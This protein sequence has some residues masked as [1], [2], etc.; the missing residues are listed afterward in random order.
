[1]VYY[2]F[3]VCVL[4]DFMMTSCIPRKFLAMILNI[5]IFLINKENKNIN[6]T[7]LNL[8]IK[9]TS[10]LRLPVFLIIIRS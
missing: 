1:M 2:F 6:M 8:N 3:I 9:Q 4:V 7:K 5:F 10:V